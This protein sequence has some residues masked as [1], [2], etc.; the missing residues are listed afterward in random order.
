MA[1]ALPSLLALGW[2]ARVAIPASRLEWIAR[3]EFLRTSRCGKE[4]AASSDLADLERT[5]ARLSVGR[6]YYPDGEISECAMTTN[7]D[8]ASSIPVGAPFSAGAHVGVLAEAYRH[9]E[10]TKPGAD[11]RA[12]VLGVGTV[13]HAS[14][15]RLLPAEA[16]HEVARTGDIVVS[17]RVGGAS[18]FAVG[19]VSEVWRGNDPALRAELFRAQDRMEPFL[20]RPS[21]F[22]ALEHT[23]APTVSRDEIPSDCDPSHGTLLSSR[24]VGPG[25]YEAEVRAE[26]PV[27]LVLKETAY[28]TW[29]FDV[30]GASTPFRLVA[31]GFMA[32][33]VP[34]GTHH[35]VARTAPDVP[36]WAGVW[37]ALLSAVGLSWWVRRTGWLRVRRR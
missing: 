17:E 7:L 22:V 31:P 4:S 19:C 35:V 33:R 27:D 10:V 18:Y 21:T 23:S 12:D 34:A 25:S 29:R 36:Y 26:A 16:W 24:R 2:I 11:G 13:L 8:F 28:R 30:D 1:L 5:L 6:L 37:A 20:D 9:L 3:R 15:D 14:K 32:I